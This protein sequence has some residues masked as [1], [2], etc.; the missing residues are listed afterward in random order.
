MAEPQHN[1]VPLGPIVTALAADFAYADGQPRL[2]D[3]KLIVWRARMAKDGGSDRVVAEMVAFALKLG[4]EGG[5]GCDTAIAQLLELV[6]IALR[7]AKQ[8]EALFRTAGID[9]ARVAKVT[10]AEHSLRPVGADGRV[11]GATS[12]M[13]ARVGGTKKTGKR[14]KAR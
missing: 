7:D 4:A 2:P 1:S 12:P 3:D 5:R 9:V 10:G 14:P 11:E 13:G 6:G 8:G